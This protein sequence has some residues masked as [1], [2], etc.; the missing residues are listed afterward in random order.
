MGA[1][2]QAMYQ[3]ETMLPTTKKAVLVILV[4]LKSNHVLATPAMIVKVRFKTGL[5]NGTAAAAELH[6]HQSC[7]IV[8]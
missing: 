7:C 1:I 2:V 5:A 4:A 3:T 6:L 8:Q